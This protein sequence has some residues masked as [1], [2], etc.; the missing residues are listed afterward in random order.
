MIFRGAVKGTVGASSLAP[1]FFFFFLPWLGVT[2]VSD[3]AR[4]CNCGLEVFRAV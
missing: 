2:R 4:V 1:F 3:P